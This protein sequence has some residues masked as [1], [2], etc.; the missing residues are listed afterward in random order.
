MHAPALSLCVK[1]PGVRRASAEGQRPLP[2][3]AGPAPDHKNAMTRRRATSIGF[4]AVLL[5]ALLALFTVGSAPVPP[6]QLNAMCFAIGGVLGLI[7]AAATGQISALWKVPLPAFALGTL[8]LFGYHALYFA[9]LRN[10]P[11]AQAGLIA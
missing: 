5:W 6:L 2:V 11:T 1:Y 9:A 4:T 7:W 10:A 8:G 3:D